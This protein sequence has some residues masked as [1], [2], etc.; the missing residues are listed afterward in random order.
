MQN[1]TAIKTI[2]R[3]FELG[4]GLKVNFHKSKIGVVG[5]DRNLVKMY[6]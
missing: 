6:S 2:L 4:Y 3:C 1:I 5:V